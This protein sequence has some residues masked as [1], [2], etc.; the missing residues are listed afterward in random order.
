MVKT[1]WN[2]WMEPFFAR[3][4]HCA[5]TG[6]HV[7]SPSV[8]YVPR[9][10]W[11]TR[12]TSFEFFSADWLTSN[13]SLLWFLADR[14][15]GSKKWRQITV[16]VRAAGPMQRNN[17]HVEELELACTLSLKKAMKIA[18]VTRQKWAFFISTGNHGYFHCSMRGQNACQFKYL[19][20]IL[21]Y[22]IR[23]MAGVSC[24]NENNPLLTGNPGY[25][26]GFFRGQSKTQFEY[27][28]M[29]VILLH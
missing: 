12:K 10:V 17:A 2:S 26:H 22:C 9:T 7:Y 14:K 29:R 28:H 19:Y 15:E 6:V 5:P 8:Y 3:N 24:R 20:M 23:I 25:F 4:S 21:F 27:L 13:A 18:W 16:K 11:V 1:S